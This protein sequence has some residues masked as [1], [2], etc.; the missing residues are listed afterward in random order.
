MPRHA[1]LSVAFALLPFLG[2]AFNSPIR[3][4]ANAAL[5]TWRLAVDLHLA[6]VADTLSHRVQERKT[7]TTMAAVVPYRERGR[8]DS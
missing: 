7:T 4:H 1:T 2:L 8:L 5:H 6:G 3:R